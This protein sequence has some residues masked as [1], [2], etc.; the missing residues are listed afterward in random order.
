[1]AR[2]G[3]GSSCKGSVCK[4]NGSMFWAVVKFYL[5]FYLFFTHLLFIQVDAAGV[6]LFSHAHSRAWNLKRCA[7]LE[8]RWP[9]VYVFDGNGDGGF[10][11]KWGG[12][13][14]SY[15]CVLEITRGE[16]QDP[17][18][19]NLN[20]R[21]SKWN[22]CSKQ[23]VNSPGHAIPAGRFCFCRN[24]KTL[25]WQLSP[26]WCQLAPARTLPVVIN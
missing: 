26:H 24:Q 1:M 3:F 13:G 2:I 16:S 11:T 14:A 21:R 15:F 19:V 23:K 10:V 6:A 20:G 18:H 4:D 25:R 9:V 7:G 12:V 8:P 17:I 5:L 22:H